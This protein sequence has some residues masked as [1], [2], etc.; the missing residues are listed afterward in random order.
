MKEKQNYR[1]LRLNEL[2]KQ[3]HEGIQDN[4]ITLFHIQ[5]FMNLLPDSRRELSQNCS[6]VAYTKLIVH[7]PKKYTTNFNV[8]DLTDEEIALGLEVQKGKISQKS[9]KWFIDRTRLELDSL[10]LGTE[11]PNTPLSNKYR[12]HSDLGTF[13]TS[14]NYH[15]DTYI[16]QTKEKM[17]VKVISRKKFRKERI[18]FGA[19]ITSSNFLN[20]SYYLA[21]QTQIRVIA[22]SH[23]SR[24]STTPSE[25]LSFLKSIDGEILLGAHGATLVA[26]QIIL[27]NLNPLS[28]EMIYVSYD[29]V[30]SLIQKSN[31]EH[32]LPIVSNIK[33]IGYSVGSLS[34]FE[35]RE[36][37]VNYDFYYGFLA[38]FLV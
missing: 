13:Y 31:G 27:K 36:F 28:G 26:E 18:V 15:H 16:D 5:W 14:S 12:I 33:N 8:T 1:T 20:S 6:R 2:Y 10:Y 32:V 4:R 22:F 3:L 17:G 24:K 9:L 19:D 23:S 35:K 37:K 25:Q 38:F 21:P 11:I 29:E 7:R 34:S 30:E